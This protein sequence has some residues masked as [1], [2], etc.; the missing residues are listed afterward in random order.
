MVAGILN[1]RQH[2]LAPAVA[3]LLY[4]LGIIFGAVVLAER[5][6][7]H[8]LAWGVVLGSIGHLLVQLPALRSVGMRWRPSFEVA[9]EGVR[10]VL[11]LMGP[12]VLGLAAAQV[13]LVVVVFLRVVRL[14]RGDQ[15]GQLRVPDDAAA[16][17]CDRDGDLDGGVPGAGQAGRGRGPGAAGLVGGRDAADDPVP[18]DSRLGSGWCCWRSPRCGCCCSAARSTR[19]RRS[20]WWT[21]W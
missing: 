13:N 18:G 20:W 4:N 6:G 12:R 16:G 21:R 15:R 9:S 8:G 10:E 5:W 3:P 17:R 1:A 11:R 14:G 19:A 7:L 2:F